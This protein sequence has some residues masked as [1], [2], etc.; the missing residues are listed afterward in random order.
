VIAAAQP[1]QV[2]DGRYTVIRLIGRGAMADVFEARDGV[3]QDKVALKILREQVAR[4]PEA[5]A[6]FKREAE[7]QARIR[8]P[9]V[10]VLHGVGL[11]GQ[12]PY[13][14]LELLAGRS[15]LQVLRHEGQ[16]PLMRAIAYAWQACQ[17]LAATHAT[18]VLHRDLKPANLVLRPNPDGTERVVL[19]DFGFAALG[20][21]A[22]ITRQG[23]VVGSL[24]YMAPERLRNEPIDVRSDLYSLACVLYELVAGRPPLAAADDGTLIAMI[25]D[26]APAPLSQAAPGAGVPPALDAALARALAKQPADRH[27]SAAAMAKALAE[28]VG[29]AG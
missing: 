3:S 15:L 1:G 19:I 2:I 28:A 17:G 9:N 25:L 29:I 12:S 6:R 22:G 21:G 8:H 26:E 4:D 20:G 13:L 11:H 23:F 7:V 5:L 18:G 27:E 16:V 14:A 10:A 24:T